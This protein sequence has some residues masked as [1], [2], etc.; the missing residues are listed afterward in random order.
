MKYYCEVDERWNPHFANY[1]Y[2][3]KTPKEAITFF[4]KKHGNKLALVYD[5]NFITHYERKN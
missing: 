3:A 5:E 4:K 2:E 1:T